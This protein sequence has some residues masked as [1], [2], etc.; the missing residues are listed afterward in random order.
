MKAIV[1][2]A[3]GATRELLRRLGE[4]WDVTVIESSEKRLND[5]KEIKGIQT[6]HGD[7]TSRLILQRS[8]LG[9]ADAVVATS[10]DDEDSEVENTH[11]RAIFTAIKT[12][13]TWAP[14]KSLKIGRLN[15]YCGQFKKARASDLLGENALLAKILSHSQPLFLR[16]HPGKWDN[17]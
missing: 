5:I 9:E 6:V 4:S 2:G 13:K 3:G 14:L 12:K 1:V 17:K 16:K 15:G 10:N 8:G 7:G 11:P